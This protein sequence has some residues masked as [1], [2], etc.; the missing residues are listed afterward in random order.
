MF[1]SQKNQWAFYK[2][3]QICASRAAKSVGKIP[4]SLI[5]VPPKG[6]EPLFLD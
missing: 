3:G 5:L 4:E 2:F 1:L 6:V